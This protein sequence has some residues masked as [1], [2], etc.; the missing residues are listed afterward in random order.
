MKYHRTAERSILRSGVEGHSVETSPEGER[1]FE[2][3][4]CGLT[5]GG[6]P[7]PFLSLQLPADSGH[8]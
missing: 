5:F 2:W 6:H 7:Q 8:A 3:K 4:T 1:S